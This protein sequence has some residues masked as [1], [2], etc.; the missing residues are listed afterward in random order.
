MASINNHILT[1]T[2]PT[3]KLDE[4]K[5]ASLGENEG[6]K[7]ANTSLGYDLMIS[8]NGYVFRD[9]DI[10]N[11][12]IDCHGV[13]PTID[14]TIID[15]LG[16]FDVDMFPRDG[17]VINVRMAA[18]DK[19]AYKDLRIDFD[20]IYV[21]TP[22]QKSDSF[23]GGKYIFM[24]RMKIPGMYSEDCK[25][26]GIGTSLEHIELIA[27]D[28]K[29]GVA[30]NIDATDDSMNLVLPFNSVIDTLNDLVRHSYIDENS[31][32][33]YSIDPF[34]YINYVNVNKL[35]N[36]EERFESV[37]L[38]WENEMADRPDSDDVDA[39]INKATTL[40]LL[41]NHKRNIGT[42]LYIEKQSIKN[43]TGASMK[44]NGYKRVLQY[45]ENDSEEGLVSHEI[46]A[47]VGKLMT[48]IE[49]PL[50]GRRDEDRYKNE[51]KYKY[52]GR[53]GGS[54]ETSNTHLNYEY[55]AVN[56]AYNMD[57]VK[58]M[59]LDIELNVF[60]PAIHRYHK[61]PVIIYN[62]EQ[63]KVGA[64]KVVKEKK[65]KDGFDVIVPDERN[66]VDP[67][68]YVV[69]EFLSGYYVVGGMSYYYKAGFNAVKQKINLLRR[70]WPSRVNNIN[71]NTTAKK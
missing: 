13:I 70:E 26:Y 37:I 24:G 56:N 27:N 5:F 8:I 28:L 38:A 29:L 40:L 6:N 48:D 32:Q 10:S 54:N 45:F 52:V 2:E 21:E 68:E 14:I 22:F 17:D 9:S 3:I 7:R 60:N 30:T 25:S 20:I 51:I 36:S 42:N 1:I 15:S 59:S 50:K 39:A 18:Q 23:T 69:D 67:S 43:K 49:E 34:Y 4:V 66:R 47:A 46:E 65:E 41:S 58:K 11:M 53:K 16:L 35:M 55:S 71:K 12:I 61:L 62:N 57:E 31:F 33:T 64:D 44:K 19:V 63:G